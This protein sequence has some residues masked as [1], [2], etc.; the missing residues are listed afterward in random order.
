M[1]GSGIAR[2]RLIGPGRI[3]AFRHRNYRLFFAGQL[4]SMVGTWM[5]QVAQA[6]LVLQLTGDPIWLG[7]VATAQFLPVM[8]LGLFAGVAAD[9]LPK[10]RVLIATQ[11]A[12][13]VLAFVLAALVISGIVQVWM[14]VLLAVLLGIANSIDMP[15][16]QS[17]AVEM[18]GRED[19]GNA[20]AL[21]SAMFNGA[22]IVGPAAAGLAIGAF[23]VA[24]AFLING[25]SFVAVIV[26]LRLIDERALLV[27][28][29]IDRPTTPRAVVRNLAE[30][31][32]YVRRTPVVL[33]AVVVVG[34]V[35][36]V[37]MNW[38]VLIPAFAAHELGSD[39]A[40]YG[41]L[42]AASG[43][44][45][46]LAAL[47]LVFGGRPRPMRL[48]TGTLILGVASVALA[49]SRIFPL[50]LG[51]MVIVGFGSILMAAT[52]NTTIQLA[53]PDHL[54][55][56]V[57]SVYT[58]VFSASV[59]IGGLAMGAIASGFGTAF[60]IGLGG[61]L[62]LAV[63]VGAL[64]WGRKGA[65]AMPG[66]APAITTSQAG[67]G[68]ASGASGSAGSAGSAGFGPAPGIAR[69]R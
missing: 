58:T 65:F 12:M 59:P 21:N 57:M 68:Q 37:G 54:R 8:I 23:G 2:D 52:G 1:I 50:S 51:L 32:A 39:A 20:V 42:M 47:R 27:P 3:T 17:F 25:L 41:F 48:A 13:M 9:A 66:P 64:A 69:P 43:V 55:G 11:T 63:G 38:G 35:A 61:I 14:I 36:T 18:V 7:I 53:V 60:A 22:R 15:V 33:L 62:S 5:Q 30:G 44:G 31:L 26:G 19:V 34:T 6:W 16:R 29:R 56:R 24:A 28:P 45:S 46:L 49:V 10:R 67:A 4:I 40:G